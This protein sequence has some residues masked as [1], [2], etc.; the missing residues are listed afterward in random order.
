VVLPMRLDVV[1]LIA[2]M[3]R[4]VT[5]AVAKAVA[6]MMEIWRMLLS[7]NLDPIGGD[8]GTGAT[9]KLSGAEYRS[10]IEWHAVPGGTP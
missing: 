1:E 6:A 4:M 2:F 10:T 5:V 7:C 3:L 9:A 8:L